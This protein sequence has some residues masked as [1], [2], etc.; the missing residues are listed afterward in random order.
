MKHSVPK[1]DHPSRHPLSHHT[2]HSGAHVRGTH[3]HLHNAHNPDDGLM[4]GEGAGSEASDHDTSSGEYPEG[5]AGLHLS[6]HPTKLELPAMHHN[7]G[8]QE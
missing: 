1:G 2:D 3:H 5:K 7:S 8:E 6:E 4:P